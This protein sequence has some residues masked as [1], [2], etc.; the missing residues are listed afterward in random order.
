[1]ISIK[2]KALGHIIRQSKTAEKQGW[3]PLRASAAV[4][5]FAADPRVTPDLVTPQGA[6]QHPAAG[7][8]PHPGKGIAGSIPYFHPSTAVAGTTT[9][10]K[11]FGF[12]RLPTRCFRGIQTPRAISAAEITEATWGYPS[13]AS[14]LYLQG[15]KFTNPEST[16]FSLPSHRHGAQ[17]R[18]LIPARQISPLT[19]GAVPG[20]EHWALWCSVTQVPPCSEWPGTLVFLQ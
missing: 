16:C 5:S 10:T 11:H 13:W 1:V 3:Q 15:I 19:H 14:N 20:E 2:A 8:S 18:V 12:S 6:C 9:T 7:S 4:S 17:S